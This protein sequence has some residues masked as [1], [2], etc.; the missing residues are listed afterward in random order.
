MNKLDKTYPELSL[1]NRT[2]NCTE[3]IRNNNLKLFDQIATKIQNGIFS[4]STKCIINDLKARSTADD[5]I[6]RLVYSSSNMS[7]TEKQKKDLE[8]KTKIK[9]TLK[10]ATKS[11]KAYEGI[12]GKEFDRFFKIFSEGESDP[13]KDYCVR[14]HVISNRLIDTSVYNVTRVP[15]NAN[16]TVSAC[17]IVLKGLI[18][19]LKNDGKGFDENEVECFLRRL[20]HVKFMDRLLLIGVLSEMSNITEDQKRAERRKYVEFM[21]KAAPYECVL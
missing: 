6:K 5:Y 18:E 16:A 15:E 10:N 7:T 3:L 13:V 11:C 8:I 4:E 1:T 9:E 12:H 17:A 19:T 2:E 14:K 20:Q 21:T